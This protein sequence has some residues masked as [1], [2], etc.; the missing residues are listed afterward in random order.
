MYSKALQD[1]FG[2]AT[3]ANSQS[4][5]SIVKQMARLASAENVTEAELKIVQKTFDEFHQDKILAIR[6]E[7]AKA[8]CEADYASRHLIL[9]IAEDCASVA[10]FVLHHSSKLSSVDLIE[11]I[12]RSGAVKQLAIANRHDLNNDVVLA[13][14]EHGSL[15]VIH[16]LI[17]NEMAKLTAHNLRQIYINFSM[18][19]SLR[20]LLCRRDDLPADLR[21]L[22][23][24]DVAKTLE[25]F[26]TKANWLNKQQASTITQ[27]SYEITVIE[28]SDTIEDADMIDYI[29]RLSEEERL[30]S[31]LI[32]RSITTGYMKF[33]E[34]SLAYLSGMPIQKL[35]SLLHN[36]NGS[37]RNALFSRSKLPRDLYPIL[38]ISIDVYKNLK[39]QLASGLQPS[40]HEFAIEMIKNVTEYYH[41]KPHDN[42]A[43]LQRVL[44][45]YYIDISHK[46]AA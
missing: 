23:A 43:Y 3:L 1:I 5:L 2:E 33:F 46:I 39:S 40:T 31:S 29:K 10:Q 4:R 17:D 8:V 32:L 22:I 18:D 44:D 15:E 30:T 12:V 42:Q 6:L 35:H 7:I 16:A 38:T 24:Y 13:I 45:C 14:I 19:P 20:E 28:I 27:K 36:P 26:V 21:E 34:Y 11:H 25:L 41:A 37:T 9:K